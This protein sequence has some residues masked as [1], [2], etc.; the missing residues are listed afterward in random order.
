MAGQ[1]NIVHKILI[2]DDD[3]D[4]RGFLADALLEIDPRIEI[5]E[6]EDGI[7]LMSSLIDNAEIPDII[8]LD[9]NMPGKDGLQCLKEIKMQDGNLKRVKIIMLSTSSDPEDIET[10]HEF[11]ASF[12][13]VKPSSFD[14][15]KL[16][17]KEV[18][19]MNL[20]NRRKFRLI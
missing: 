18:M 1:K 11:G 10:A 2:V 19:N 5:F 12:Y 8:F 20:D 6:L 13:A 7:S 17:L 3:Q 15:M 16:F 14:V 4:D 9:I